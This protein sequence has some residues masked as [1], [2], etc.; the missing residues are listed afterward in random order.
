MHRHVF[1]IFA[2]CLM[3]QVISVPVAAMW[4]TDASIA[5]VR[6]GRALVPVRALFEWLGATVDY[7]EGVITAKHGAETVTLTVGDKRALR[8]SRAVIL[9]V[10]PQIIDGRAYIPLRF[11]AEALGATVVYEPPGREIAVQ[12]GD[13]VLMLRVVREMGGKRIYPGAWF[14]I[15]YPPGFQVVEREFSL[16]GSGFDGVGFISPDEKVEFFVFSPQWR[17]ISRWAQVRAGEK[18]LE[19]RKETKGDVTVV[20]V[21]VEGP[22]GSYKRA[23][24]ENINELYNTNLYFGIRYADRASY[25]RYLKQYQE[26]KDSLIQYAD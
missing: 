4:D 18:E 19:R 26:F 13:E 11:A 3:F 16:T 24:V 12:H 21:E 8:G 2:A 23:W 25:D 10:P 7:R 1:I 17:G 9:D 14:D 15:S 6:E 5:M 22:Q 20:W